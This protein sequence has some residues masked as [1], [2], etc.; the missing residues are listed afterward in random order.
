MPS[1]IYDQF[2]VLLVAVEPTEGEMARDVLAGAGIPSMLY[3]PE[4]DVAELGTTVHSSVR[5]P[6]LLVP[7]GSHAA[8]RAVL[9]EAWGHKSVAL[10]EPH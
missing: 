7:K 5:R 3:S 6:D 9:I 1:S 4:F 8:A 10:K 2:D